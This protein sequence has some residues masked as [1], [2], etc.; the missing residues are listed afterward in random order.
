MSQFTMESQWKSKAQEFIAGKK[1][2]IENWDEYQELLAEYDKLSYACSDENEELSSVYE[3]LVLA[4]DQKVV[5]QEEPDEIDF[6]N[7]T[8]HERKSQEEPYEEAENTFQEE[9]ENVTALLQ[10]FKAAK[11][12]EYEEY[13]PSWCESNTEYAQILVD[14]LKLGQH[15]VVAALVKT[16]WMVFSYDEEEDNAALFQEFCERGLSQY[17]VTIEELKAKVLRW[18]ATLDA[19]TANLYMAILVKDLIEVLQM[20]TGELSARLKV[21]KQF[22]D[23]LLQKAGINDGQFLDMVRFPYLLLRSTDTVIDYNIVVAIEKYAHEQMYIPFDILDNE[24][25]GLWSALHRVTK[26]YNAHFFMTDNNKRLVNNHIRSSM[27]IECCNI[28]MNLGLFLLRAWSVEPLLMEWEDIIAFIG[29]CGLDVKVKNVIEE[30][31]LE[32][33]DDAEWDSL[34]KEYLEYDRRAVGNKM[35]EALAIQLMENDLY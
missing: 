10:E 33:F 18:K 31:L 30:N 11:T 23:W 24:K 20:A 3:Q 7:E 26:E 15:S 34:E 1:N 4:K 6:E 13:T 21:E 2:K 12:T 19:H 5:S 32:L 16:S 9:S 29:K 35:V 25:G 8:I 14:F 17:T 22:L 27:G 28:C